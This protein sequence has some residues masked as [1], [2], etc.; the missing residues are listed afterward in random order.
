[1]E[2]TQYPGPQCFGVDIVCS[3]GDCC[4]CL[5]QKLKEGDSSI[6]RKHVLV[7]EDGPT[8]GLLCKLLL[9]DEGY[10][11]TLISGQQEALAVLHGNTHFD[12]VWSDGTGWKQCYMAAVKK[13]GKENVVVYTGNRY[14][15]EALSEEGIKAF[16]K[17]ASDEDIYRTPF[18]VIE[19]IKKLFPVMT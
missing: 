3:C 13:F 5:A 7:M 4:P 9:E 18:G 17:G 8:F 2:H 15:V 6:Q 1:M 10:Q 16:I 11:V 14:L 19:E 12:F